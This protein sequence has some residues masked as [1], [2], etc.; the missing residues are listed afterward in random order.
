MATKV[1]IGLSAH[2]PEMLP[3][4]ADLMRRHDAVFLEEY[5]A[6]GFRRM[7]RGTLSIED[8]LRRI[9]FEY[10]QFSRE[11]CRLLREFSQEGIQIFQVEPF[12][13]ALMKIHALFAGGFGPEALHKNSIH[14]QVYNAEG[15]ATS[16]LIDYYR[17]VMSCS[18]EETVETIKRFARADAARFRL[19]DALR[20]RAL[21]GRVLR[22]QNAFVEAGV[23]HLQLWL[24]LQKAL[25]QR[26]R[27]KPVFVADAPLKT[28]GL[29][30]RRYGPG[31]Q[32]TLLYIFQPGF[33]ARKREQVL[34]A[35]SVIYAKII[36]KE[37]LTC[38]T[39]A[40][41]HLRNE[42]SCIRT[43]NRLSFSDCR[44]LFPH[45]RRAGSVKARSIVDDFL[46]G[47]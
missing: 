46:A 13:S 4:L 1:T 11:L 39:P 30:R 22:Y 43:V 35:R 7:L 34:A 5:P 40:F 15:R 14:F 16:A 36:Q 32:L 42:Q 17:T 20:A 27:V 31:D 12:L 37:E 3:L 2:R 26:A 23:I 19:R 21:A 24:M 18:L 8:Y 28:L 25:G 44:T 9:D 33:S 47:S 38:A 29:K 10:P 6:P 45:I 41:P